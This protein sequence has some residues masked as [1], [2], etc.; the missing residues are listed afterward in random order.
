M[1]LVLDS[2]AEM[3]TNSY[4][5]VKETDDLALLTR[6]CRDILEDVEYLL[7]KFEDLDRRSSGVA[8]K[9]KK[10]WKSLTWDEKDV[11]RLR[12]RIVSNVTFLDTFNNIQRRS[13]S[14]HPGGHRC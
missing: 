4:L 14:L 2:V 3:T 1:K 6:N 7:V 8:A 10:V 12:N 11:D 13:T 5:N 9:S